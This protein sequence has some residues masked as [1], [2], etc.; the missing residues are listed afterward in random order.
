MRTWKDVADS[1][2]KEEIINGRFKAALK[3]KEQAEITCMLEDL[4]DTTGL[5]K[6]YNKFEK[7]SNK[8]YSMR[9]GFN[10]W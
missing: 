3:I 6:D 8:F 9:E 1:P 5:K 4:Y 2:E 7:A 10:E